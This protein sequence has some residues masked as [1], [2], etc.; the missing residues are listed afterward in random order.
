MNHHVS[1]LNPAWGGFDLLNDESM[2]LGPIW[3]PPYNRKDGGIILYS[4]N[5]WGRE[6]H[7]SDLSHMPWDEYLKALNK[8]LAKQYASLRT[9]GRL[10]MLIGDCRQKGKL[11]SAVLNATSMGNWSM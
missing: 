6:K 7:A 9:G 10:A 11:Y 5:M 8:C 3:F 4:G 2:Q 1:D